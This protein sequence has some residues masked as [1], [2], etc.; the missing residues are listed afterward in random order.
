MLN[1]RQLSN[2]VDLSTRS[3]VRNFSRIAIPHISIGNVG[4]FLDHT[5]VMTSSDVHEDIAVVPKA[6][7]EASADMSSE[8]EIV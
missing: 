2:P 3:D 4:E 8:I 1:L 5:E 6:D 7:S